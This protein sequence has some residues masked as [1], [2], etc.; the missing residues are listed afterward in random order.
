M[1]ATAAA[2]SAAVLASAAIAQA[3]KSAGT[4]AQSQVCWAAATPLMSLLFPQVGTA[5]AKM[6]NVW[7]GGGLPVI[8][9]KLHTRM[10]NWEFV[11]LTELRPVG[12]LEKL[13]PEP[14]PHRYIIMPGLEVARAS[15]K[16]IEDIQTWIQ[17][18]LIYVAVMATKCS[19]VI[20]G[21]A[22][23]MLVI[24]SASKSIRSQPGDHMM[25]HFGRRQPQQGTENGH[26]PTHISTT[27][28]PLWG[29]Y[30]QGGGF[31]KDWATTEQEGGVCG[32]SGSWA[33][34]DT[35]KKL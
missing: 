6:P 11:D 25:R 18:F 5:S 17:C 30:P 22:A 32:S 16:L 24:I 35:G 7:M 13:N 19:S 20:L 21:M 29:C 1:S 27:V 33:I 28:C 10:L 34:A 26:C 23:Y 12:T 31:P 15:K 14:D 9:K 2:G 4:G 3:D 8:P